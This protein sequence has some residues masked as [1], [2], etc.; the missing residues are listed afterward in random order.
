MLCAIEG[1]IEPLQKVISKYEK[2]DAAEGGGAGPEK[3][4]ALEQV[5]SCV[6]VICCVNKLDNLDVSQ[7]WQG[8]VGRLQASPC[9]AVLLAEQDAQGLRE[10]GM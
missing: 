2:M 4:R 3:E 5:R 9:V 10:K 7:L 8:F 6:R 1:F